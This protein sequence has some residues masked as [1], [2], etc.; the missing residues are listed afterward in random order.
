MKYAP[1]LK[2]KS[3]GYT[4]LKK[5]KGAACGRKESKETL[6]TDKNTGW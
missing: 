2:R 1:V 5:N 6:A 3:M 4:Y